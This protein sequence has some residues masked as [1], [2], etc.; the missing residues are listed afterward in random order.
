MLLLSFKKTG[1]F[2]LILNHK[3]AAIAR[4]KA[5]KNCQSSRKTDLIQAGQ[6]FCYIANH[7]QEWYN[8]HTRPVIRGGDDY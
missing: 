3:R 6:F 4:A 1:P 2:V 5:A 7:A 8:M